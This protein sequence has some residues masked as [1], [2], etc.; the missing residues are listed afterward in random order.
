MIHGD[1]TAGADLTAER[2]RADIAALRTKPSVDLVVIGGGI[3]GVGVALDAATRGLDVVLCEG[4]DLAFGTSRWS[5]KLVHG[6]LRYLANGQ[7]DVAWESAVERGHLMRFIAPHLVHPMPQVFPILVGDAPRRV[8]VTR[9]GLKAGD[10][11]RALARTSPHLLPGSRRLSAQQTLQWVPALDPDQV[12]GGLL[13]WDGRLEDDARLVVAVARTAAA[14]GARILT[15]AQVRRAD[16]HGVEVDIDGELLQIHARSVISAVGVWAES[17]DSKLSVTPSQGTHVLLPANRLGNPRAA[18]TVPVPELHGRYCFILPRPDDL[19]LAGITDI[20]VP[21]EIPP[22]PMPG[23]AEVTWILEQVSRVLARPV[24]TQ[25]VIGTFAGL[26]PLVTT[27]EHHQATADISRRHLVRC[28]TAGVITI[29]GGKLTTYRRMAQDVVDKVTDRPCVTRTL[30][31]IGATRSTGNA[32]VTTPDFGR[33]QVEADRL[34]RRY[35]AEAERLVAMA[36]GDPL[37]SEPV[38]PGVPVLGVEIAF[39]LSCEGA[40][41]FQD[42]VERRT[43]LSLVPSQLAAAEERVMEIIKRSQQL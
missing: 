37:L 36:Q 38:A 19:L 3:T 24:T 27:G 5:S 29:A 31:L 8:A 16:G 39:A 21:G 42:C 2:R 40:R 28:S 12:R 22:V 9:I 13:S 18:L 6:G 32:A 11:L 7:V 33:K 25:D 23:A 17:F 10:A 41:T 14:Y 1:S 30:P 15:G 4:Q 34:V 35:G 20:E 26:R 43:R